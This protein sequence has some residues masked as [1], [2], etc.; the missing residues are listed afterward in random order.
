MNKALLVSTTL[1]AAALTYC[2]ASY[3]MEDSGF[4]W[5]IMTYCGGLLTAPVM[6]AT[7][8]G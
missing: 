2:G 8:E 5:I 3:L 4:L 1:M 6:F 7:L